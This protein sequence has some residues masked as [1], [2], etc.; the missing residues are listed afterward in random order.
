MRETI[1]QPA[2]TRP[3]DPW[4]WEIKGHLRVCH[5]HRRI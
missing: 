3:D 2:L 5:W 4:A 1:M